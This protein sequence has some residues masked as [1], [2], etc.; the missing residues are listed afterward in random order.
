MT[1]TERVAAAARAVRAACGPDDRF[2]LVLVDTKTGH[3]Q[4]RHNLGSQAEAAGV[5][6]G[7]Y[8]VAYRDGG[9]GPGADD[10][11]QA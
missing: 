6:A 10:D 4:S 11:D 2:V 1:I 5:V 8:E 7:M 9:C 3:A